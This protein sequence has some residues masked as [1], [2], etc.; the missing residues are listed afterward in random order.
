MIYLLVGGLALLLVI[1][2]FIERGDWLAPAVVVTLS[3][4]FSVACAACNVELWGIDL[5]LQTTLTIFGGVLLFGLFCLFFRGALKPGKKTN[6]AAVGSGVRYIAIKRSHQVLLLV[7][8][9]V[10]LVIYYRYLSRSFSNLGVVDQDW[11]DMMSSYRQASASTE[12]SYLTNRPTWVTYMY[13]TMHA[14]AFVVL[15]VVINNLFTKKDRRSRD[16]PLYLCMVIYLVSVILRAGRL[17]LLEYAFAAVLIAWIVW[18]RVHGWKNVIHLGYVIAVIAAAIGVLALFSALR[19]LVGRTND[20]DFFTYI[21]NYAG[22]SIQLFDLFLKDPMPSN[23][24][25]GQETFR[26]IVSA[27]GRHFNSAPI[28]SWQLEFRYSN[29]IVLGN[30]YTAFRYWIYDFGYLGW[31]IMLAVYAFIYTAFHQRVKRVNPVGRF[32]AALTVYAYL[33][34]GLVML[35][36]QDVLF[37]MDLNPGGIY[38]LACIFFFGWLLVDRPQREAAQ[39]KSRSWRN[40]MPGSSMRGLS[41]GDSPDTK[42]RLDPDGRGRH[43]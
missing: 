30:V 6:R 11:N 5:G 34:S 37:A 29:G 41:L 12:D 22:G 43:A 32:D 13:N 10:T 20:A 35:P 17:P 24:I 18:H 27:L 3:F 14:L 2:L 40:E 4:L 28:F 1:E 8:F 26:G 38:M 39:A 19:W 7:F 42:A 15:C 23:G 31:F 16:L 33:F 21:T 25:F 36:I 9:I